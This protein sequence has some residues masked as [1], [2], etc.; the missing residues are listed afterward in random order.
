MIE[1]R[2]FKRVGAELPIRCR[3]VHK[4]KRL[5]LSNIIEVYTRNISQGGL[6]LSWPRGWDCGKCSH[7]L[8]WIF[9]RDCKLK[10]EPYQEKTRFLCPTT[11]LKLEVEATISQNPIRTSAEIVWP[12][13]PQSLQEDTY[14]VGIAFTKPIKNKISP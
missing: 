2:R 3:I 11:F 1:R 5:P 6:L 7:C 13:E 9:N 12:R 14:N 4:K 10:K 8:A